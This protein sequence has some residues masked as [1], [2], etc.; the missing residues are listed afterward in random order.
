MYVGRDLLLAA[1]LL[2]LIIQ[3]VIRHPA[4]GAPAGHTYHQQTA[5][6]LSSTQANVKAG[7]FASKQPITIRVGGAAKTVGAGDWL[8]PAERVAAYQV[9]STGQQS[10]ILGPG[11]NAVGGSMTL[12]A[13]AGQL[14]NGLTVPAGVVVLDNIARSTSLNFSGNLVNS[15]AVYVF[16]SNPLNTTASITAQNIFNQGGGLISSVLP[17]GTL[18]GSLN[19]ARTVN[20][21]LNALQD[22]VNAGSIVS[23]GVL[24][25]SAGGSIVNSSAGRGSQIP[26][27][28]SG[29]LGVQL[30]AG[31]GNIV[32]TGTIS[33]TLG[34]IDLSTI[35]G[36]DL[37][38]NNASGL[39]Q[40]QLGS[41]NVRAQSFAGKELT[42]LLG[43]TFQANSINL[44]GGNGKVN[45]D[46]DFLNGVSNVFANCATIVVNKGS[47]NLGNLAITGDPTFASSDNI[48]LSALGLSDLTLNGQDLTILSGGNIEIGSLNQID[49]S[50]TGDC[51]GRGGDLTIL[52]G[53]SFSPVPQAGGPDSSTTFVI[54]GPSETGGNFNSANRQLSIYTNSDAGRG[55]N[56]RIVAFSTVDKEGSFS[57]GNLNYS[58][59]IATSST[60]AGGNAGDV[61]IMGANLNLGGN[62]G[63]T[64]EANGGPAGSNGLAGNA[65]NVAFQGF[66]PAVAAG[67]SVKNGAL[68]MVSG[69]QTYTGDTQNWSPFYPLHPWPDTFPAEGSN[70][71]VTINA[72]FT[73]TA[74][75]AS[76]SGSFYVDTSGQILVLLNPFGQFNNNGSSFSATTTGSVTF[77]HPTSDDPILQLP[78]V[79]AP[80]VG[81]NTPGHPF[82]LDIPIP[83]LISINN[84]ES[85]G[86][87]SIDANSVTMTAGDVEIYRDRP[88]GRPF[89]IT[90]ENGDIIITALTK[91]GEGSIEI[92]AQG[93][94]GGGGGSGSGGGGGC[95]G[96]IANDPCGAVNFIARGGNILYFAQ[97]GSIEV[98]NP[99]SP[100]IFDAYSA[101]S[102]SVQVQIGSN[103][104]GSPIYKTFGIRGGGLEM[105]AGAWDPTNPNHL[106]F[107]TSNFAVSSDPNALPTDG[108]FVVEQVGGNTVSI[109]SLQ[110]S[111][112]NARVFLH[113]GPAPDPIDLSGVGTFSIQ[114]FPQPPSVGPSPCTDCEG[115]P[116]A[117]LSLPPT[118][119]VRFD[120][121]Q[122]QSSI[123]LSID[124]TNLY[125]SPPIKVPNICRPTKVIASREIMD[126]LEAKQWFVAS[127]SCQ[128][129]SMDMDGDT[130]VIGSA[131]TTFAPDGT[132]GITLKEGRMVV[133]ASSGGSSIKTAL[134]N[135][136]V[137]ASGSVIVD[138]KSAGVLR[139]IN[140]AG[141]NAEVQI[142]SG[143]KAKTMTCSPGQEMLIA[144]QSVADEELIDV[145]GVERQPIEGAVAVAGLKTQLNKFDSQSMAEKEPLLICNRGCLT[146]REKKR[147]KE[148]QNSMAG[149]IHKLTPVASGPVPP[150]SRNPNRAVPLA[151]N[152]DLSRIVPDV[153]GALTGKHERSGSGALR[154]ADYV[155]ASDD[156]SG[157][158]SW[159]PVSYVAPATSGGL[160]TLNSAGCSVRT[161]GDGEILLGDDGLVNI[162]HGQA[163]ISASAPTGVVCGDSKIALDAGTVALVTSKNGIAR[164]DNLYDTH[165]GGLHV[166]L[167]GKKVD[168]S[169][170]QEILIGKDDSSLSGMLKSDGLTR[171]RVKRFDMTHGPSFFRSEVSYVSI[172]MNSDL[173]SGL[174]RSN[175]G[176]DKDLLARLLKMAA[177]ITTITSGHGVYLPMGS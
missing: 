8:T 74:N 103:P 54:N 161:I 176:E 80:F 60:A 128:P 172:F 162:K 12:G 105:W 107:T 111:N 126:Q 72:P 84:Q 89:N 125:A 85:A 76:G 139:V 69:G 81:P 121:P 63:L 141:G 137:G 53:V 118:P 93:A 166:A 104:D 171:R 64:I 55:G 48:I 133:L 1:T 150:L 21:S 119:P 51:G 88:I 30:L 62:S 24:S 96:F 16:S 152:G 5:L 156:A 148:I 77:G 82:S 58:G 160:R 18:P 169:A 9:V 38:V 149:T 153:P 71:S 108:T 22:I 66:V 113:A 143:D 131:G 3:L 151:G 73:L 159:R 27:V 68:T 147:L 29:A 70:E 28:L 47:L 91:N 130:L 41:I 165:D 100:P 40:A 92:S 98:T 37:I 95:G 117:V 170:G 167:A 56:V 177:C 112:S 114:A 46:V 115:P 99:N 31:S 20:L 35:A 10:L 65:G 6:D 39:I 158:S 122:F 87:F 174:M 14:F 123:I 25:L 83:T 101:I 13:R 90:A 97:G 164:V 145:N 157:D 102:S 32:N 155:S 120:I 2:L 7:G 15:G 44:N 86:Q 43:G 94:F 175:Y 45:V 19:G 52:A 163:L 135:V 138:E 124:Q 154:N 79:A 106:S 136:K 146:P 110:T 78:G 50:C 129:F 61:Q 57:G 49:L 17:P 109:P 36:K 67:T 127:N 140:L 34:N 75:G 132:T 42:A 11:G 4:Y 168:L 134:G 116:P 144:D 33:A 59:A 23:S 26:A 173:L 142:G